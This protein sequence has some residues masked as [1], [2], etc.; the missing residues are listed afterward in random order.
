MQ[1]DLLLPDSDC[2]ESLGRER[3]AAEQEG[4]CIT[5]TSVI[6]VTRTPPPRG[7]GGL[8][9]RSPGGQRRCGGAAGGG[10]R[11]RPGR[12]LPAHKPGRAAQ[13]VRRAA[14]AP[15]LLK[16]GG[17]S[18]AAPQG[19]PAGGA[20]AKNNYNNLSIR[21]PEK[22]SRDAPSVTRRLGQVV[23]SPNT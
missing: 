2:R 5:Y 14:V 20:E 6:Y 4:T 16:R 8:H 12:L 11:E 10:G 13:G 21:K 18:L 9:A 17:R 19:D 7:V 1:W 3:A 15:A 22:Q 23:N